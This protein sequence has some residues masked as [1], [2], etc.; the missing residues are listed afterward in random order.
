MI[1]SHSIFRF[2]RLQEE[3]GRDDLVCRLLRSDGR[4]CVQLR[5]RQNA[6]LGLTPPYGLEF[7]VSGFGFSV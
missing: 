2:S 6:G 1:Y 4:G 7:S 5:R 3:R